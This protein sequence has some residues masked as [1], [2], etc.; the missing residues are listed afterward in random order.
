MLSAEYS[1]RIAIPARPTTRILRPPKHG[2]VIQREQSDL[3]TMQS[4]NWATVE[5][6]R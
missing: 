4:F 1:L 6:R 5:N 2:G 3:L